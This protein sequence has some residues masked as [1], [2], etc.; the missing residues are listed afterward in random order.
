MFDGN[1]FKGEKN[2]PKDGIMLQLQSSKAARITD[3][4]Q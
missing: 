1:V 4:V 2:S 3:G